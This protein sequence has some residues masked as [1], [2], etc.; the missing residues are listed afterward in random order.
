MALEIAR[1]HPRCGTPRVAVFDFDGT[2][3]LIRGGWTGVMVEL[4]AERLIGLPAAGTEAAIRA[5]VTDFVLDLNG[6]PTIFQ[7]QRFVEELVRCG[8]RADPPEAYQREYL[9]RLTV[10]IDERKAALRAGRCTT[11]DLLVPG[12]RRLLEAFIGR[13]VELT[14][15]SGTEIEF[16]R[17]EAAILDIDR[18]FENRIHGPGENPRAFS[19]GAVMRDALDRHGAAG[20]ALVG[21]GD[22]IAEIEQARALGGIALGVASDEEH[23]SGAAVEWKRT[24]LIDAGAHAIVPDYAA[25]DELLAWLWAA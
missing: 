21:I 6:Q 1:P 8:G 20:E 16:V 23:R 19:K 10:R 7:M 25:T 11:D 12:A 18:Y 15:A 14:L 22:G 5:R 2:L 3:S 17:E 13:G 4:M 9:R 24:R